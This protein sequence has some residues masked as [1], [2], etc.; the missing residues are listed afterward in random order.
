MM[1]RISS[2][3]L[4]ALL[5][6]CWLVMASPA[7]ALAAEIRNGPNALV[8]RSET[9]DDDLFAGSG[10]T[11]TISGH[12]TGDVYAA[13]ETVVVN[14]Q[15]DG[16]LIAAAQQVTVDGAI[17]GNVRA[18]GATVTIN[19]RVGRNLTALAQ[20]VN[21]ASNSQIMGSVL[22][23]GQTIDAFGQVGRGMTVGGG[24][25]QLAGTVG[26]SVLARVE[27]LTVAP[28]ARVAGDLEYQA[29]QEASI[30]TGTVSGQV[31][32]NPAPQQAPQPTPLLNGLFDLGGL[33]GLIGSF[34]VGALAI[35]L[36]PRSAARAAELGRQQPWQSFGLGVLMLFAV[37][38]VAVLVGI[39]L[40]GIPLAACMV[41]LYVLGII[42]AWPAAAL[43]L[44]TLLS[45][46]VRPEPPLPILGNLAVGLIVLHLVSHL[47]FVG[48]LVALCTAMFG[49][50]LIAQALRSWG[51][52]TDQQRSTVPA[53]A[54]A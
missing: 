54:T 42:L 48:P 2:L 36:T 39:T 34:L 14:G 44:G 49:L 47:P 21:L 1:S 27:T 29:K 45:R 7:G 28:T 52:P 8:A 13:A 11:V 16:D 24:T 9:I 25:F 30:P 46:M 53:M 5:A 35:V 38:I 22:A 40:I 50:G 20:H 19:G 3:A 51:K 18:A 33:I 26:G 10:Q 31:T 32:F 43:V 4:M 6:A 12:V 23:A 41:A 37:P 17:G 15:I